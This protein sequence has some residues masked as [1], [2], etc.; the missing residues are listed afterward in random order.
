MPKTIDITPDWAPLI[1]PLCL[2]LE[3]PEADEEA[4]SEIEDELVRVVRLLCGM[5]K[6]PKVDEKDKREIAF[7]LQRLARGVDKRNHAIRKEKEEACVA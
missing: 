2:V 7:D 6:S 3:N 4:K 1:Q 5:L